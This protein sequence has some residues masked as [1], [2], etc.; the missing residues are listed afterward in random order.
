[1]HEVATLKPQLDHTGLSWC[2]AERP[3]QVGNE[4]KIWHNANG[5]RTHKLASDPRKVFPNCGNNFNDPTLAQ[6]P[7]GGGPNTTRHF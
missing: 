2:D 4:A 3:R 5:R 6:P 7:A 1:M